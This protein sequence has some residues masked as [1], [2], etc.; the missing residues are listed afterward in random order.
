MANL[1]HKLPILKTEHILYK[2]KLE[3]GLHISSHV[4]ITNCEWIIAT[5]SHKQHSKVFQYKIFA[6]TFT[7]VKKGFQDNQKIAEAK[8]IKLIFV[9]ISVGNKFPRKMV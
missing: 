1:A 2:Q 6:S 4:T 9:Q 5:R 8:K 3:S 7:K